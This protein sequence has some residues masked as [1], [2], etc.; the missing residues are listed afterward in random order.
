[1]DEKCLIHKFDKRYKRCDSGDIV[2]SITEDEMP[3]C[4]KHWSKIASGV[5][6]W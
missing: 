3:I 5:R 4:R 2:V 6:D 1:M